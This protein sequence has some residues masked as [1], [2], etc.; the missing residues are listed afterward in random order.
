MQ[1]PAQGQPTPQATEL[2]PRLIQGLQAT[3]EPAVWTGQNTSG[4]K[5][6]GEYVLVKMDAASPTSS[7]GVMLTDEL[8]E[9]MTEA[10]ESGCVYAIGALAFKRHGPDCPKVGERVYIE[11]YAGLKAMGRDGATYRIM[12]DKCIAAGQADLEAA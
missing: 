5:P 8:I 6:F 4:L 1:Q 2:T 9:R 11:K 7:G 10:A 12:E 3:F